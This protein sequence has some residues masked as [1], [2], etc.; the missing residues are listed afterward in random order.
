MLFLI[1]VRVKLVL[2][3]EVGE[4]EGEVHVVVDVLIQV[5]YEGSF[6]CR[7]AEVLEI[8]TEV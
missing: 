2:P 4:G 6:T 1:S 5:G 7:K 8:E 3:H